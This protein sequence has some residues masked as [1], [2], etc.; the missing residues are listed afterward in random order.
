MLMAECHAGIDETIGICMLVAVVF[1]TE[2]GFGVCTS[3]YGEQLMSENAE[4]TVDTG[5]YG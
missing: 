2:P 5:C 4:D 3:W 1:G